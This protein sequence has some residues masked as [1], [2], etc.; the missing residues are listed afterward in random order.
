MHI[1]FYSN[2][3]TKDYTLTCTNFCDANGISYTYLP[4]KKSTFISEVVYILESI[5]TDDIVLL[6]DTRNSILTQPESK[7]L[8]L[9]ESFSVPLVI[10]C[11]DY[12]TNQTSLVRR[13][14]QAWTGAVN[15]GVSAYLG[16]LIGR[17]EYMIDMFKTFVNYKNL[18]KETNLYVSINPNIVVDGEHALFDL[19][20]P[21]DISNMSNDIL[22]PVYKPS[23]NYII[24][25]ASIPGCL[26]GCDMSVIIASNSLTPEPYDIPFKE[27][28]SV[29]KQLL[30]DNKQGI[31][32]AFIKGFF[33]G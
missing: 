25:S 27:R 12:K 26:V 22:Y 24:D 33:K 16:T 18:Y 23:H 7:I 1:L 6:L 5:L 30:W 21:H 14:V 20:F 8:E 28:I 3:R 9:Y 19:Y 4:E 10:G 2:D 31:F 17:R 29:F 32:H 15:D 13:I 11:F